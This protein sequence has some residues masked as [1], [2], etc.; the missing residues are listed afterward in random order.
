MRQVAAPRTPHPQALIPNQERPDE[1]EGRLEVLLDQIR[2]LNHQQRPPQDPA[3]GW[4][5]IFTSVP[6]S[7]ICEPITKTKLPP[8]WTIKL[9]E[10]SNRSMARGLSLPTVETLLATGLICC[11]LSRVELRW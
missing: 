4:S 8:V 1:T 9:P 7:R 10:K 5:S 6:P 2:V 11:S 3:N